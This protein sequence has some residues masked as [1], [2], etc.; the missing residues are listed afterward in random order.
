MPGNGYLLWST[1]LA[2]GFGLIRLLQSSGYEWVRSAVAPYAPLEYPFLFGAVFLGFYGWTDRPRLALSF[3][4]LVTV[5]FW[6][7]SSG[8]GGF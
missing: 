1:V 8:A 3:A 5:G 4:I 7:L 2:M 6:A